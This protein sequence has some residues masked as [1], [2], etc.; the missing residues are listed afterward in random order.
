MRRKFYLVNEIGSTFFFDYSHSC[1]IEE[2]DGLGFEFDIDYE[3]FD[4]EYVET[5]RTT[6]QRTIDFTLIF[7]DGYAGFTRWREYVTKSKELRL[8]Y[9]NT[10]GT[11][12]CYINIKSSSKAQLESGI[13]RSE[14]KIDCLSF[15]LVNKS[16][17]L[18][19]TDVG[20]GKV[21]TY[22]YP[23]TYSV[24][25]NGR[26]TVVNDSP[27]SIPLRIRLIG[28]LYNPRVIIRQGGK[29]ITALRLLVDERE[30]PTIEINASPVNQYIK[31][32]SGVDEQDYYNFQDFSYDNFL[33]LPPGTSEIFFDPGVREEAT[34][35]IF[36][37]EEYIAH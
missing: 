26:I 37:K 29:D 22:E 35:E 16:Y 13:L 33:Y 5:K 32:I 25:F 11:K 3:N 8:F 31:K 6:P 21:Y 20:G 23:C 12:Y 15:W 7:F 14:V 10:S 17:S 36:F 28:N 24:S 18:T 1:V 30:N 4:S 9:Q 19:V 27:K 2:L 34:C